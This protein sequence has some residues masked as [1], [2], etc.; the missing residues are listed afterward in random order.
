MLAVLALASALAA[1]RSAPPT[2]HAP[3]EA[4]AVCPDAAVKAA[5]A[6][7]LEGRPSDAQR[8]DHDRAVAAW[9]VCARLNGV[10]SY[11][12]PA[13]QDP[14]AT[15]VL[16]AAMTE[17]GRRERIEA[18]ERSAAAEPELVALLALEELGV[19]GLLQRV[20]PPIRLTV[21]AAAV[22]AWG[23]P[24]AREWGLGADGQET[25]WCTDGRDLGTM[26]RE[27]IRQLVA[28]SQPTRTMQGWL[29]E[30]TRP[31]A[32]A[33][34][35]G[36]EDTYFPID[37]PRPVVVPTGGVGMALE[38]GLGWTLRVSPD[39]AIWTPRPRFHITRD[40][41]EVPQPTLRTRA[42]KEWDGTPVVYAEGGVTAGALDMA[43]Q[44]QRVGRP[45]LVGQGPEGLIELRLGWM[46]RESAPP[47]DAVVVD[48]VAG[49]STLADRLRASSATGETWLRVPAG[50]PFAALVHAQGAAAAARPGPIRFVVV[51]PR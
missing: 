22:G 11:R 18:L 28:L 41:V 35:A 2:L 33:L 34:W 8:R 50:L 29:A 17:P 15:R 13:L 42:P 37:E 49:D 45:R 23:C 47:A 12:L 24:H 46:P 20:D 16:T 51:D 9:A 39:I 27:G 14:A 3:P 21:A 5:H 38:P 1:P 44:E 4:T 43:F 19:M 26:A 25:A 31:R 6:A 48:V 40:G 36:L 10:S 32:D 30:A 7:L